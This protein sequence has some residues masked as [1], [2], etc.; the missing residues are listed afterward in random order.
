[1]LLVCPA[2]GEKTEGMMGVTELI[3]STAGIGIIFSLLAGQPLL[4]IGFSGPL[5]VFEEAYYKVVDS[6]RKSHATI[7]RLVL[8][9]LCHSC[10]RWT[11]KK[12]KLLLCSVLPGLQLRIPDGSSVDWLLAHLHRLRHRGSRGQLPRALHLTVHPGDFRFPHL[13]HLYLRDVFQA[14]QST[15]SRNL[16]STIYFFLFFFFNVGNT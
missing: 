13:P 16:I 12:N 9:L 3:V 8:F 5:L 7:S 1:M 4:V 6:G 10:L 14:H 2:V 15:Y 11:R